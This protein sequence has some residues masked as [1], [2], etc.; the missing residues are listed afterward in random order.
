VVISLIIA[1]GY[2]LT[3]IGL[4][5]GEDIDE[6]LISYE[7]WARKTAYSFGSR[8]PGTPDLAALP[9][10]LKDKNLSK[11]APILMRIF[12]REFELEL[13]MLKD[14]RFVHFATYPICRWSGRLGPKLKQGD[15]Q[16]PEGYYTVDKGSL[17]PN[18]QW[19]RS[20][21]LGYPNLYDRVN[22][23]TGSLIMVHGGCS[24]IGCFAMTNAVIDELWELVTAA[25][26]GGQKRFQVQVFPFRM[27]D[28]NMQSR[29][30]SPQIEFWRNL[31]SGY[32]LFENS[33]LPPRVSIC[34]RQ[35]A[36]EEGQPIRDG[37]APIISS[38]CPQREASS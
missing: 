27:S 15:H 13:W 21:N 16:A 19:H 22:N 17:N 7:R 31:K 26:D 34:N 25:L 6:R 2:A 29:A 36:F 3:R 33:G 14:S 12:K 4:N 32:V 9:E 8:L 35:Y 20:F 24:S 23:R 30:S 18:S 1:F 5:L 28:E 10:R 38:R 37:S 11:G